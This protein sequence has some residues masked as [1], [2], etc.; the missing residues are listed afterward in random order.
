M[1]MI[2]QCLTYLTAQ[3]NA[4]LINREGKLTCLSGLQTCS[5]S[6]KPRGIWVYKK[7]LIIWI[8]LRSALH[9][10]ILFGTVSIFA[11][12]C[13][14]TQTPVWQWIL[15]IAYEYTH[16]CIAFLEPGESVGSTVRSVAPFDGYFENEVSPKSTRWRCFAAVWWCNGFTW[17][18]S[19][20]RWEKS[21]WLSLSAVPSGDLVAQCLSDR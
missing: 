9:V 8:E 2:S 6:E 4:Q 7:N 10:V 18:T 17:V 5:S 21:L 11:S 13:L 16:F 20:R 3:H 19:P 12:A 15:V 14:K 1:V